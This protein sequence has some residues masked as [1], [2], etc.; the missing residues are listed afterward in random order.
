MRGYVFTICAA[1]DEA[2]A[3]AVFVGPSSG[4]GRSG[5]WSSAVSD[6][7]Q[8]INSA[9]DCVDTEVKMRWRALSVTSRANKTQ[10][11]ASRDGIAD[12]NSRC[13]SIE[14]RVVINTPAGADDRHCLAAEVVL[15]NL[16]DESRRR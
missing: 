6:Q 10:Q 4:H 12:F 1:A 14:V 5:S 7:R 3:G 2:R 8:R 15:A 13:V 11:G 16:V 9:A